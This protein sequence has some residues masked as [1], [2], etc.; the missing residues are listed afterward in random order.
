MVQS[1]YLEAERDEGAQMKEYALY[2]GRRRTRFT[3]Y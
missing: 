2:A 3:Y 1:E